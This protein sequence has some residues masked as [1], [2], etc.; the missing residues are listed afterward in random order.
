METILPILIKSLPYLQK[1]CGGMLLLLV[2]DG[3]HEFGHFITAK[4]IG[5]RVDV[6]SIG[7]GKAIWQR[8]FGETNY[9]VFLIPVPGGVKFV[10]VC[11]HRDA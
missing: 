10:F 2:V 11:N 1:A 4:Y 5:A 7:F 8:T 9:R 3:I 6:F